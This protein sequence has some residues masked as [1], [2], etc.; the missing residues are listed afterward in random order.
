MNMKELQFL[1]RK[2]HISENW[3]LVLASYA[4]A[5]SPK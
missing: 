5:A 1:E 4:S 3:E 2:T